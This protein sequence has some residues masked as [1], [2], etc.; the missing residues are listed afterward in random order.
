MSMS[1]RCVKQALC[2]FLPDGL[3]VIWL[4]VS[5]HSGSGLANDHFAVNEVAPGIYLHEG[6]H[7]QMTTANHGDIV[8]SGFIIGSR[9][10]A[11][12]DPGGSVR[13]AQLLY[14]A[15][16]A[17]T[18][19]P[20]R[21]VV[22]THIHPDHMAGVSVFPASIELVAHVHYPRALAQRGGFYFDRFPDLF[23]GDRVKG[24]RVPDTLVD[25]E[26]FVDLGDRRL[27][28]RTYPT[29]HTD[30]DLSVF[31]VKTKTLFASDLL[32]AQRTPSLDGSLTGWLQVLQQMGEQDY[33]L[34]IPGHG[35]PGSWDAVATPQLT[36][37]R[38]LESSVS[39]QIERGLT[40]S[41]TID[42]EM[43]KPDA[44]GWQ[45]YDEVHPVNITKAYTE[46]EWE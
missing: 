12:I 39:E 15:I 21:F 28:I 2:R 19:L 3:L 29:A 42:N 25:G 40:L 16:E 17:R 7:E 24:L 6:V 10:V 36:Y 38:A 1:C 8:N 13:N 27:L 34:V 4:V 11:V 30:N 45:L 9:S 32:F 18:S 46:L 43:N 37:L 22:L 41:E 33:G 31:D 35:R 20:V 44:T 14:D 5:L 26:L 23:G